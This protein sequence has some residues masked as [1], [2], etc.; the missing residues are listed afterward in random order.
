MKAYICSVCGFLYDEESAEVSPDGHM[1]EFDKL[2]F[3]EWICPG[4]GVKANLFTQTESDR[5]HDV[6]VPES[7]EKDKKGE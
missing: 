6:P 4:C 7:P 5:V 3:D 2:D 1:I